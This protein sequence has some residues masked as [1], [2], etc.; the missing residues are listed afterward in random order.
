[1][2]VDGVT[3][4]EYGQNL[5]ENLRDLRGRLKS[6]KYRHQP[7]R[8]VHIPKDQ[9]R[10]RPIGVSVI[11]D[12]IV[13][14]ALTEILGAIYEQDFLECSYGF[15]P[16]RK[17]HDALRSLNGSVR[18]GGV[19]VIL[20]ADIFNQCLKD[21]HLRLCCQKHCVFD[22]YPLDFFAVASAGSPRLFLKAHRGRDE[23]RY[24]RERAFRGRRGQGVHRVDVP[25]VD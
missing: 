3:K 25:C 10:T 5:E 17:A 23:I 16:G 13:Q 21:V 8:R 11:E 9:H 14:G 24:L 4:E 19:N 18:N 20:E 7:I 1:V 22:V 12:K 6:M 2:G 15:R